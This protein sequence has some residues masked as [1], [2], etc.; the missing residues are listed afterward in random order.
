MCATLRPCKSKS[1]QANNVSIPNISI[2][3]QVQPSAF[4]GYKWHA[5]PLRRGISG[6]LCIMWERHVL[7]TQHA[8]TLLGNSFKKRNLFPASLSIH[9]WLKEINI[10]NFSFS[11]STCLMWKGIFYVHLHQPFL[12]ARNQI[13]Q[14]TYLVWIHNLMKLYWKPWVSL[15]AQWEG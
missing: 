3:S 7:A 1:K 15:Q 13:L 4:C 11:K 5:H 12:Y 6:W 2:L 8:I 10:V 14:K 9:L